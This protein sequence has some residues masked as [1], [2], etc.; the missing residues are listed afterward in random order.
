MSQIHLIDELSETLRIGF[1]KEKRPGF[2]PLLTSAIESIDFA[3]FDSLEYLVPNNASMYSTDEAGNIRYLF[4]KGMNLA[5]ARVIRQMEQLECLFLERA[6]GVDEIEALSALQN[7]KYLII[8][9][10]RSPKFGVKSEIALSSGY[11]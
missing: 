11:E 4:C 2:F 1:R 10:H 5:A 6:V 7:L 3:V 9:S 8:S